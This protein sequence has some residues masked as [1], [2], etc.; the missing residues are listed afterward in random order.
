MPQY[1]VYLQNHSDSEA[2]DYEVV[3]QVAEVPPRRGPS[4]PQ[5]PLPYGPHCIPES[6]HDAH[7]LS[8]RGMVPL[9]A[10]LPSPRCPPDPREC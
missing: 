10:A 8:A 7:Q 4:A 6:H 2:I 3:S 5:Y 9:A 1:I